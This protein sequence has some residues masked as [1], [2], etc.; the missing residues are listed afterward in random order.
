MFLNNNMAGAK[1]KHVSNVQEVLMG[2]FNSEENMSEDEF[3]FED[4]QF[5]I[6]V[7]GKNSK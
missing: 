6:N 3:A 2:G 7:G 5:Q 1:N 4:S